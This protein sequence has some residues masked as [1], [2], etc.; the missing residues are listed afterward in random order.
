MLTDNNDN[1]E[2]AEN[3]G[4]SERE[5][6]NVVVNNKR[7]NHRWLHLVNLGSYETD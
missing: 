2:N 1:E 6:L 4:S 3:I 5:T 7:G